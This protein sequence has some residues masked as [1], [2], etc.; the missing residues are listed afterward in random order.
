MFL[1]LASSSRTEV[2]E[3]NELPAVDFFLHPCFFLE[4]VVETM[5]MRSSSDDEKNALK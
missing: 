2:R 5:L 1:G 4:L 3:D